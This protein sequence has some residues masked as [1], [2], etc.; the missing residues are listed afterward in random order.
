SPTPVPSE[1]ATATPTPTEGAAATPA[2]DSTGGTPT[3]VSENKDIQPTGPNGFETSNVVNTDKPEVQPGEP[4]TVTEILR[5]KD[6]TPINPVHVEEVTW[7]R[8]TPDTEDWEE[9]PEAKEMV[10]LAKEEDDGYDVRAKVTLTDG[11]EGTTYSNTTRIRKFVA[12]DRDMTDSALDTS[13]K[14]G[15]RSVTGGVFAAIGI[16]AMA[17]MA[18]VTMRLKKYEK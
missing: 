1:G 10:Y 3:P 4:V 16:I 8:K 14:T 11:F 15:A 5:T 17:A 7:E 13:P 12:G 18:V 2:S 6:G 9:I